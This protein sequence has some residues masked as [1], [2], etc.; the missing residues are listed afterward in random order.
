[1]KKKILFLSG[2]RADYGKIK[3]LIQAVES[4]NDFEAYIFVSG[5]HLMQQYGN[6][7]KEII[8]DGYKNIYVAFGLRNSRNMS[9]DL[10]DL[11]CTLTGYVEKMKPDMIIVHG[12]RI[13]AL[14][15][16]VVGALH[17]I[18]VTHIEGGE[19]SGTIDESIRHTVSKMAHLHMVC[20]EE[21]KMRLLQ[22][23]EQKERVHI[24]GSPDVD[25]MLSDDLPTI[26]QVKKRYEILF[27]EYAVLMY[28]PVTTEFADIPRH[29]K[30]VVD[31]AIESGK[32]YVVIYPNNDYGTDYIQNEFRRLEDGKYADRFRIFPSVRFEYFLSLLKHADF[33][34]GNSSAGIRETCV[35]GVPAIDVGTRQNNRYSTDIVK[36]IQH[37]DEDKEAILQAI[38]N[39]DHYRVTA[40]YFGDGKSADRFL[41]I[42]YSD[43]W[44]M[45]LQKKFV[46]IDF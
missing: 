8:K 33:I 26:E 23:G 19:L 40:S 44:S 22:M 18:V 7:Y 29:V 30:E 39:V 16:A 6:T 41:D 27:D 5:M 20:N 25:V 42:L 4:S 9:Y 35:Y 28:H 1:M 38:S 37:T 34:L 10:G 17:N 32:N 24:L 11:I 46:D 31:A 21:A 15:G 14:A 3:P 45:P 36:N 43:I 12:D 2:T 13:E